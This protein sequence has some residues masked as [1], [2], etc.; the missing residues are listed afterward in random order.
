MSLE[1]IQRTMDGYNRMIAKICITFA[2]VI[3][4]V[5]AGFTTVLMYNTKKSYDYEY[6]DIS[7]TAVSGNDNEIG[8]D[9]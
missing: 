9:E 4:I 6:P 2:I 3:F 8:V 7:T 5:V 1:Q